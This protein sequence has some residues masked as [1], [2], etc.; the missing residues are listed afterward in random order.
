M[1]FTKVTR[2][3][4]AKHPTDT[5][6]EHACDPRHTGTYVKHTTQTRD[7]NTVYR[8]RTPTHHTVFSRCVLTQHTGYAHT[9][10][11]KRGRSI[12]G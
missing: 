5:R 2:H 6:H 7:T 10:A 11:K 12:T 9:H 1:F 4:G 3:S 8:Y